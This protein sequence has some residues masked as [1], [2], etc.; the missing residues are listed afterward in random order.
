[1]A[2][3]LL[4]DRKTGNNPQNIVL[5]ELTKRI[6]AIFGRFGTGLAIKPELGVNSPK[7]KTS[8]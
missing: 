6:S 8:T 4:E 2:E 1:M 7:S 5:D 3:Y